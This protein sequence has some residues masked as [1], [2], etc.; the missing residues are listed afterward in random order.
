[1][2]ES[3]FADKEKFR[4]AVFPVENLSGTVAPLKEIRQVAIDKLRAKGVDVLEEEAL[5]KFM[6]KYRI[7]Y[8][9]GVDREVAKAFEQDDKVGGV[10]IISLELYSDATPPKISL[11]SRL[12]STGDDPSILWM[13][14]VGLAGDDSPG[15]LGLGLI[16]DPK[17]LLGKALQSLT[18]S[19]TVSLLRKG[20][21]ED[22][23]ESKRKFK[24]KVFFRSPMIDPSKK[25]TVAVLPFFNKSE[26]RY[27][28]EIM[29]LQFAKNLKEL[30]N[31][32]V[33]EPGLVRQQFLAMRI[34]MDQGVSLA[35]ADAIFSTLEADL[36]VSGDLITYQ[37]YQGIWGTPKV[38][39]SVLFVDRMGRKV[40]WSS[41]SYNE[42]DDGVFFFDLG[43]VN[44]AYVMASQMTQRIG[45]MFIED[46]KK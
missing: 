7:R 18:E 22:V 28:G 32:E 46:S 8:T 13:D 34:I 15:I 10:L 14:G 38:D 26:T 36:V 43:R 19:L 30:K 5:E 11:V 3:P 21:R 29:Q 35:D 31:F 4:I 17:T 9:G 42:G 27:G 37:D 33:V 45:R 12:V 39:F 23:R 24:P 16:E 25:Y 1:M 41:T 2:K 20:G 6:A 44:T 40:V